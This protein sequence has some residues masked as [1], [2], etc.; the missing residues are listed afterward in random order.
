MS[1]GPISAPP[2]SPTRAKPDP[3]TEAPARKRRGFAVL[4]TLTIAL[5]LPL[6]I[7]LGCWQL[8]RHHW[9]EALLA[10][11]RRN[12]DLPIAD[13]GAGPIPA[14]SQFRHVRLSLDCP[15]ATPVERAG[16]SLAGAAGFARLLPCTHGGRPLQLDAGWA[17]R[18][19]PSPLPA[20]A[21]AMTGRLILDARG[22]WILVADQ[23]L[24]PLAAS[25]PPTL[26]SIPN[27]H[28]GYAIQ[29]FSFAAVL[30]IIYGLWLFR[31]LAPSDR[32][33]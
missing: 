29:W 17:A 8:G 31:R 13:L 25:A 27:N 5:A 33:S 7:G 30:A 3:Q 21:A 1:G 16:R 26:D 24:P 32:P 15:S 9:K 14:D 23:P 18:P 19:D 20:V 28:L 6:L 11:Y 12:I 10:E 4:P 22:G 2:L